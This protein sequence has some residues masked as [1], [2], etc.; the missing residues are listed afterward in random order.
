MNLVGIK[1]VTVCGFGLIGG[2]I[3]LDLQKGSK[4]PLFI[5]Y[6]KPKVLTA[7]KKDKK[8]K[9]SV[10]VGL[11]EAT[12]GSDII[13]LAATHSV[14]EKLLI[15]LSKMKNLTDCLIIDT[16][17]VK[18]SI[19]KLSH[20]LIFPDGT[21]F[22]ASHPMSGKEKKGFENSDADIFKGHAWFVDDEV[23]L[24]ENNKKRFDW[25]IKKT[26]SLPVYVSSP[27]H[28]Q[29]VSEI[30][31]LPQ[32]ISTILGAQINPDMISLA[33]PGLKSMLRLAGSPYSV[34]EEIIDQN[35]DEVVK[36]LNLYIDNLN[37]IVKKIKKKES[38]SDI[39]KAAARSYKCLS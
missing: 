36:S 8:Y 7:L 35:R 38:L 20:Q 13:I 33:G 22:L 26:K 11:R 18:S 2:S 28:D 16:G 34:W 32:L 27:L 29:L 21:Q 25:L 14:N 30:S 1:K 39:F 23:K 17:A 31:H 15:Q 9:V 5:A 24:T 37:S 19:V 10:E 4:P 6:D 3:T 12:C